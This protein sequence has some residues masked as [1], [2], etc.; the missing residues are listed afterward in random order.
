ML[1]NRDGITSHNNKENAEIMAEAFNKLL[2]CDEPETTFNIDTNT[3]I[4]TKPENINPPTAKEVEKAIKEMK[5][6]KACGEDSTFAE[7]WK[8]AGSTAQTSLHVTFQK[9]WITEKFPE[10][11]TKAIINPIHKKGDKSNPDNYRGISLLDCTYKI[12]SKILY[13]R[14]KEQLDQELG[15]YQGGFRP[16]RSCAEQILTLKLVMAYYKQRNKPLSI[17]FIDFKKAYDSIHRPSLL[18]ILRHFGLHP[19][20]IKLIEL[21]LTNT[22][23]KIKFRGELS[24][25]FLIRTG[26]RQGDGLSPLLFNCAL[27]YIM[28]EWYSNNPKNILIGC[29]KDNINL[30]CL[31]FADDLALLAN[32]IQET[33]QQI[34]SL[35]DIANKIG[36]KISFEK[37]EIMLTQ[38]PLARKIQIENRDIKIV[39]K[40]RYLGEIITYNLSEKLTWQNRIHKLTKGQYTTKNTYNKKYLSIA[41]KLRHYQTV[42]QPQVTYACETIFK[43]TNTISIDRILKIERRIVRTCLNKNYQVDGVWRLAS[44]QTVYKE[45]EPVTS[46]IKKKRIS[47]LGHL[48]RTPENRISRK[49]IEKLWNSRINIRWITEL[50][51]DLRELHITIED[52]KHKT[53]T[54]KTLKDKHTT[55]QFKRNNQRVG[56]VISDEERK[57]RS[58]RMKKYWAEK[59]KNT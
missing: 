44:N 22:T 12:F 33:K 26:L 54:L 8:Y 5:N 37:T 49:I 43:T 2:N 31:G 18:K 28:R 58:E 32:N 35:H 53:D 3:T 14:I 6:Y 46:T 59:K 7:L 1:K 55:L 30:N 27:E 4:K 57:L 23:S 10:H 25:P 47:F 42:T 11:W 15:D 19:K 48:L 21:T 16:W 20:L 45:I 13:N 56:R 41:T 40:F 34:K 9:I 52:L 51:E 38:P 24:E 39:D 17:T 50:K 36:L 29:K